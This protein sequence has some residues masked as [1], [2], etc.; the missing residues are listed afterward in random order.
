MN[1][2][3]QA[4]WAL[5]KFDTHYKDLMNVEGL[6]LGAAPCVGVPLSVV[7]GIQT[8]GT[9][10]F[11]A[12]MSISYLLA[13][14]AVMQEKLQ[15]LRI[16]KAM[17]ECNFFDKNTITPEFIEKNKAMVARLC[18]EFQPIKEDYKNHTHWAARQAKEKGEFYYPNIDERIDAFY[19]VII[20]ELESFNR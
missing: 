19:K 14:A 7:F 3:L 16:K 6:S 11:I 4:Q 13:V 9:E 10:L 18:T 5:H 8:G 2:L 15:S 17:K 12:G 1:D 20:D